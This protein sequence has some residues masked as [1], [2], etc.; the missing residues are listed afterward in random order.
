MTDSNNPFDGPQL[1]DV[2]Y[3]R[4]DMSRSHFNGVNLSHATFYAVLDNARFTDTNLQSAVFDD[5]NLSG[6]SFDNINL[7]GVNINN[8]NLSGSSFTNLNLTDAA[9][10]SANYTGMTI[11]GVLV[12]DLL[13]CYEKH[14]G[15]S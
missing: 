4:A 2:E 15:T 5:V 10:S 13:A 6:A 11:E 14:N 8:V 9:I 12:S 3:A 7:A 1:Q